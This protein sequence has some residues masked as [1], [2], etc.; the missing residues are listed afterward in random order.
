MKHYFCKKIIFI[1]ILL[2]LLFNTITGAYGRITITADPNVDAETIE[3]VEKIVNSFNDI[4]IRDMKVLLSRDVRLFL[5]SNSE[6]YIKTLRKEFKFSKR[7]AQKRANSTIGLSRSNIA[8][9]AVNFDSSFNSNTKYRA[10]NV[11]AHE[12]AHQLQADLSGNY[13]GG[14]LY[15]MV[16]GVA[17]LIAA[18]VAS[19]CGYES[20]EKWKL[21]RINILRSAKNYASP[22]SVGYISYKDWDKLFVEWKYPYEVSDLLVFYLMNITNN[23]FYEAMSEYFSQASNFRD[24]KV[25]FEEVFGISFDDFNKNSR[26]WLEQNY[27]SPSQIEVV[28]IGKKEKDEEIK[29]AFELSQSILIDKF[30][31]DLHSHQRIILTE[32]L[33][34]YTT[35]LC[36]EFGLNQTEAEKLAVISKFRFN[37][38]TTVLGIDSDSDL[39]KMDYLVANIMMKKFLN[40]QA[41]SNLLSNC[42]WFRNGT[43][44]WFGALLVDR[45]EIKTFDYFRQMWLETILNSVSCPL[46]TELQTTEQWDAAVRNYGEGIVQ[47]YAALAVTYLIETWG[48]ESIAKWISTA[49][50]IQAEAAF[51]KVFETNF[52]GFLTK[53]E[54]YL[55]QTS[56]LTWRE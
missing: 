40:Q 25:V 43:A 13:L 32:D 10:Y 53:Y 3:M 52:N 47:S 39:E 33:P 1:G 7:E 45:S 5:C 19:E 31:D 41:P 34:N 21:D 18:V 28:A 49:K 4:L 22:E 35:T 46:L 9:I 54:E 6:S 20:F 36:S 23:N 26:E 24:D 27:K 16:E 50:E 56:N 44:D 14:V 29:K 37:T 12:L 8:V 15:W 17:D 30:N 55:D 42:Y 38:G 48:T 51:S 11:T 2:F